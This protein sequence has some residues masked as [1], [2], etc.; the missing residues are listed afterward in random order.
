[1][2]P[3]ETVMIQNIISKWYIYVVQCI[4][5]LTLRIFYFV[6]HYRYDTIFT[7][8]DFY[9]LVY[10]FPSDSLHLND[11]GTTRRLFDLWTE[12]KCM[13]KSKIDEMSEHMFQL[14][15]YVPKEMG[16]KPR[17]IKERKHYKGTEF[18]NFGL[19]IG[20]V[21][22]KKRMKT[23]QHYE[24]FLCYALAYRLLL[25]HDNFIVPEENINI[26]RKLLKIFVE[27]FQHFYGETSLSYNIHML[28]HLCD[29]VHRF[30]SLDSFSAYRYENA[31]QKIKKRLRRGTQIPQ[32]MFNRWLEF[33]GDRNETKFDKKYFSTKE[34]D[35]CVTLNNGKVVVI[36]KKTVENDEIIFTG[37]HFLHFKNFF[38]KPLQSEVLGIHEIQLNDFSEGF[39]VFKEQD[40]KWKNMIFP[41]FEDE[42]AVIIPI[43]HYI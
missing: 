32:Q 35:N 36:S 16:R 41:T 7:N 13:E 9:D 30:G 10:D 23:E 26:A 2:S 15:A 3:F 18:R 29:F 25:M 27:N 33:G 19:N 4:K 42:T 43:L 34:P 14:R 20:V 1:M 39:T 6:Y 38:E 17:R 31:Y 40:I 22:L 21:T 8:Y 5:I 24:H 37:K 12:G 28:L 11:L